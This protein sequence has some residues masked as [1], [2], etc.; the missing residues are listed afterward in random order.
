MAWTIAVLLLL[1]VFAAALYRFAPGLLYDA[2]MAVARRAAR[3]H[4][5]E[6]RLAGERIAYL[7]G[8]AGEPLVLLHGFGA[9]KDHWTLIARQLTR[10]WRVIAPDIPGFGDSSRVP[11]ANYGLEA[12]LARLETFVDA[13]GLTRFHLGGNSMGGYLA[14]H[15]AAR[16]PDRV[17]S[18]SLLAPAG[19]M[20][21][22]PSELQTAIAAGDNPLLVGDGAAFE[23]L[24]ALCFVK[25]PPLP[26]RFKQVLAARAVAE[27]PFNAKLFADLFADP[28]ALEQ[29]LAGLAV[30]TLVLWG[31]G[32]RVLHPAG[33]EI[34]R[35]VIPAAECVLM[36]DMGHV[37]MV[38][39]PAE[40]TAA[41]QRFGAGALAGH[42]RL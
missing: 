22:P 24:S 10:S 5:A 36:R 34:L 30:P 7:A 27:A 39:G 32:D 26:A 40:V 9:N 21:A 29:A 31:D 11:Q 3:L 18:L 8:G 23:R 35:K 4:P 25:A 2:T 28:L 13:L 15:F 6:A 17:K 41:L 14:A 42:A 16:H 19:V 37:P 33:L 38:E 12:Q 1:L 20:S